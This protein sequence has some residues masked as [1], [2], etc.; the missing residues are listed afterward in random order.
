MIERDIGFISG[1]RFFRDGDRTMFTFGIDPNNVIGP[2]EASTAEK[3]QFPGEWAK[4]MAAK[5]QLDHDGDGR[6]GGVFVPDDTP[7]KRKAGRP[8]KVR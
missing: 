6:P 4:F 8:P 1:A 7:P 3:E 2:H 5:P